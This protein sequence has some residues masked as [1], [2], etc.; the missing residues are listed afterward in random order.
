MMT[1]FKLTIMIVFAIFFLFLASLSETSKDSYPLEAF[2]YIRMGL[3]GAIEDQLV[4]VTQKVVKPWT[5][6]EQ[7]SLALKS[8]LILIFCIING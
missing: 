2:S 5:F 8:F 1:H 6:F 4:D 3:V 7:V